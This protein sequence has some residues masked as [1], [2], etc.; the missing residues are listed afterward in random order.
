MVST[1]SKPQRQLGVQMVRIKLPFGSLTPKQLVCIADIA[2]KYS[3][4]NLHTTTRQDIQLHYIS[5]DKVESLWR[6]LVN[7]GVDGRETFGNTVRNITASAKAGI[8]PEEL[9]DVTPYAMAVDRYFRNNELNQD[10]GRKVKIAFSSNERDSAYAFMNDIGFIPCLV[11][12]QR[13]FKVLLGGGMAGRSMKG[14]Y[15]VPF[16]PEK[17][18]ISFIEAVLRVFA[19]NGELVN[20][21][22][23]RLKYLVE[24][25]GTE[26]FISLVMEEQ[27]VIG[28][29][30]YK[31][32]N[33]EM[34]V[35]LIADK[36]VGVV[37]LGDNDKYQK[38]LLTNT[39]S[40]K[41]K[42]FSAVYIRLR[43]GNITSQ[44][45]K[46]LADIASRFASEHLRITPNQG[47]QLAY[48]PKSGLPEIYFELNKIGLAEPGF[49]STADVTACPGTDTCNLG[50]ANTTTLA[51]E[52][53][54]LVEEQF[55]NLLLN[56]D[57]KIKISGCMNACGHHTVANIGL[58]ATTMKAGTKVIPAMQI[59]LGGGV[60]EDGTANI[61]EKLIVL[62]TKR[63]PD[64]L[65][66]ILQDF[67]ENGF[68]GEYFNDYYR[69]QEKMYFFQQLLPLSVAD[70]LAE[71]LAFDWDSNDEFVVHR[72]EQLMPLKDLPGILK[73][74]V[75]EKREL[76]QECIK[77]KAYEDA[78][79]HAYTIF[80]RIA[81]ILLLEKD[82]QCGTQMRLLEEFELEFKD[83]LPNELK[84]Y[85]KY[86]LTYKKLNP[87]SS[88]ANDYFNH[89]LSLL[90]LIDH[91]FTTA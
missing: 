43:L 61:A 89:S 38:W 79:Y 4:G 73:I 40:Q 21:N 60:H 37:G 9:F 69:R 78:L 10:L 82:I 51:Q 19:Q 65:R 3:N 12:N 6:E 16:L 49:N 90:K 50:I 7:S 83:S 88:E 25:L 5:S 64:A 28:E 22:K 63:V 76:L 26:A 86:V 29:R 23:G 2:D 46:A 54:K 39:F 34:N 67:E 45:A 20:R 33:N 18:L 85:K 75:E 11:D 80:V 31:L 36:K 53:E 41:Q 59:L 91:D 32:D 77:H 42:G 35:P 66:R 62:P 70:D 30:P 44:K 71:T 27:A 68:P 13:G 52:I 74:Q 55:E 15:A 57:L 17:G 72:P 8:D 84:D 56:N 1:Y 14:K 24:K 81:K 58:Q 87:N 48:V 47:I